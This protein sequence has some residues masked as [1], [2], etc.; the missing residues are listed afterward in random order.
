MGTSELVAVGTDVEAVAESGGASRR[1]EGTAVTGRRDQRG[2]VSA[3]WAVGIIA[4]VAIAGVL[5]AVVTN[6]AVEDALLKFILQV[7]HSFSG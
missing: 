3:E 4:A 7:I 1:E 2:M 5:L 6:G